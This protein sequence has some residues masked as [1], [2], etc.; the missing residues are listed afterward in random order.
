MK[1]ALASRASV[2]GEFGESVPKLGDLGV[3]VGDLGANIGCG[4]EGGNSRKASMAKSTP[5]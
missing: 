2:N 3:V 5:A 4:G 1:D